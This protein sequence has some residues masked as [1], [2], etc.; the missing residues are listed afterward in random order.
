M[1]IE[2]KAV[3]D[4]LSALHFTARVQPGGKI[5][6][7]APG[8]IEGQPV[9]VFVILPHAYSPPPR[10]A[11]DIIEAY[12]AQRSPRSA[13]DIDRQIQEERDSWEP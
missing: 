5:Q 10:S 12:R 11:L 13:E 2:T 3:V 6:I 4:L 1:S 8:L 9:E 7:E